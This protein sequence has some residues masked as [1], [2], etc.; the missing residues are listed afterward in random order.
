MAHP[1]HALSDLSPDYLPESELVQLTNDDGGDTVV[2]SVWEG[3]VAKAD[4]EIDG[5][6][7][8]R[9]AV[10]LDTVPALVA[11][12]SA[13]LTLYKLYR[14][15]Y[16]TDTPESVQEDFKAIQRT[17]RDLAKGIP[18]L[19]S[20]PAPDPNVERQAK[21]SAQTAVF[22]RDSLKAYC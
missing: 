13:R 11:D 22:S 14:R 4:G 7:G 9:Y 18:S 1:Y 12:L 17:L 15:R 8:D 3:L 20:Q 6:L 10:P 19:G 21:V 2:E 16:G 5:W